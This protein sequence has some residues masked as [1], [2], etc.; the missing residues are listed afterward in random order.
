MTPRSIERVSNLEV[1]DFLREFEARDR[2]VVIAG[3]AGHWPAVA[4]W[5]PA[6]L[7]DRIGNVSTKFKRSSTHQHPD[8]HQTE[9]AALE[10]S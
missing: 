3:G 9:L 4:R 10:K 5:N 2:P 7:R 6:Y 1:G 8:F